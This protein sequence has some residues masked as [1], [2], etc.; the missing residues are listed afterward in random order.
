M[1]APLMRATDGNVE[2]ATHG[3]RQGSA[4]AGHKARRPVTAASRGGIT[5]APADG[6]LSIDRLARAFASMMGVADPYGSTT[7]ADGDAGVEVDPSPNL[8]EDDFGSGEHD[9][10]CR[11]SPATILEALL[12][13]GLPG[14]RSGRSGS[15][16]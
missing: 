12:F 6:G 15:P 8:D 10:T 16:R 13:V 9:S 3:A 14:G 5:A 4:P 1:P 11:V 2:V 7:P